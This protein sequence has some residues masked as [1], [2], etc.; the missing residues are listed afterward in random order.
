MK[1]DVSYGEEENNPA[2]STPVST[3]VTPDDIR[4]DNLCHAYNYRFIAQP[5]YFRLAHSPQQAEE[6]VREAVAAGKR[7]TVRSGGHCGEDFVAAP[8]VQVILDLSPMS[9]V[10]FDRE[11]NAFVVE[12]GAS[13]G[14]MIDA[15]FRRWGVTV[16]VGFCMGV[17]AGG[18]IS[19]GGY[20]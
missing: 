15:L 20:G 5:D 14:T 13:V 17:G 3:L 12:A 16:P 1:H 10:D 7:I 6:A 8:D 4:Y 11:R 19:G 2:R 9:R 18:H